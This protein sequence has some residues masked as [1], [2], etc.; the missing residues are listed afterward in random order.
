[1]QFS[2]H[3]FAKHYGSVADQRNGELIIDIVVLF[4]ISHESPFLLLWRII[5]LERE[6]EYVFTAKMISLTVN[7]YLLSNNIW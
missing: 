5:V 2:K 1:M 6:R 4:V 7:Q 3:Y